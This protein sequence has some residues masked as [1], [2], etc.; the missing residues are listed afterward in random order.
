MP[1]QLNKK[2]LET[3]TGTGL[4]FHEAKRDCSVVNYNRFLIQEQ[5][6]VRQVSAEFLCHDRWFR[7]VTQRSGTG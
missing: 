6:E 3:A 2:R 7:C 4:S 5:P 1:R